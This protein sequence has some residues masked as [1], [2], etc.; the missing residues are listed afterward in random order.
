M[1]VREP[2]HDWFLSTTRREHQ[3]L[4]NRRLPLFAAGWLAVTLAW[5]LV[6]G[7]VSPG[8]FFLSGMLC[9][10]QVVVLIVALLLCRYAPTAAGTPL[11]V[12]MCVG[13]GLACAAIFAA[14]RS[15]ADLLAFVLLALYVA[16]AHLFALGWAAELGIIAPTLAAYALAIPWL[17]PAV[18]A[19][20]SVAAIVTGVV[21]SLAIAQASLRAFRVRL[22][23]RESEASI[24]ALLRALPDMVLRVRRDGEVLDLHTERN[25]ALAPS[26]DTRTGAAVEPAPISPGVM[27]ALREAAS[28]ALAGRVQSFEYVRVTAKER[29]DYEARVVPSGEG[30][31]FAVVRE[32]SVRR[33]V[34]QA[35]R[36]S[37]GRYRGIV[38]SSFVLICRVDSEGRFTFL[39]DAYC[40]LLG[41]PLDE[42]VG[43]HASVV[44]HEDDVEALREMERTITTPSYRAKIECRNRTP[45]GW[46]WIAWEAGAVSEQ[47]GATVEV[48]AF[49]YDVTERRI[50]GEALQAAFAD[51]RASE[52]RLRLLARHQVEIRE[53][54]RKRMAFDLHD[55]V[56]QELVGVAILAESL[57]QH[58]GPLPVAAA[59]NLDRIAR[60]L[61]EVV[62]HLRELARDMRPLLL[63]D[64]GLEGCLRSLAEGMASPQ[65]RVSAECETPT[66]RLDEASEL[67][68]YRIAQEALLNSVRHATAR[69]VVLTLG[70]RDGTLR[71]EVRDDGCGFDPR[72]RERSLCLGL[73]SMEERAVALGARFELRSEPHEGT[74]VTLECPLT[75]RAPLASRQ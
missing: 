70:A 17:R 18:P 16:C 35:L 62:D 26:S 29:R 19:V 14:A 1:R 13:L 72:R 24:R 57:R 32:I 36:E 7:F 58:L 65:T 71:L 40:R 25:D 33:R 52:E 12:L 34:E 21:M 8:A 44:L 27:S 68:I 59:G 37:E 6:L 3:Q 75:S 46:V 49:G 63:H 38:E 45:D 31:I 73:A 47:Q 5:S 11:V 28:R 41:K 51:L 9:V 2:D 23:E 42:L 22:R 10:S 15:Y 55:D 30:E 60:S 48:Q 54:E 50:A 56:C 61:R 66:P 74:I 64:L 20:A 39:N 4:I 67:G 43:R 69:N 53:E